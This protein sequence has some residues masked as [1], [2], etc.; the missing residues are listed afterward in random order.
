MSGGGVDDSGVQLQGN[1]APARRETPRCRPG[2]LRRDGQTA[3]MARSP[4]NVGFVPITGRLSMADLRPPAIEIAV[5]NL[6]N[7]TILFR[8]TPQPGNRA[9]GVQEIPIPISTALDEDAFCEICVRKIK[10]RRLASAALEVSVL[11]G[12]LMNWHAANLPAI[13]RSITGRE[14]SFGDSG[15]KHRSGV[16]NCDACSDGCTSD[17]DDIGCPGK[18]HGD[19]RYRPNLKSGAREFDAVFCCDVCGDTTRPA[20]R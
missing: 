18:V 6:E 17:C 1:A 7:D 3:I 10:S 11:H 8:F 4:I 19:L 14:L 13:A 2:Q 12:H 16:A 20:G 9:V 5:A 15:K